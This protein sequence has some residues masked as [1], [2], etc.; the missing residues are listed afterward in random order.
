MTRTPL[1]ALSL[2]LGGI[3]AACASPES[4]PAMEP[5]VLSP[6]LAAEVNAEAPA[7]RGPH[8]R[9]VWTRDVGD[10]TDV[11]SFGNQLTLMGYDSDDGAGERVLLEQPAGYARPLVSASGEEIVFSVRE[12]AA[13]YAMEW[14]GTGRRRIADGFGLTVWPEPG[15]GVEWVYVGDDQA[16][17]DPPSYRSVYR[18]RLD[19]TGERELVWDAQPVSGDS[20]QL[21]A[22]GRYAGGLF[23]WPDAGVADLQTGTWTA[24]GDGCWTSFAGDGSDLFW[25]FDGSHRSLTMVDAKTDQRWQ[26]GINTAPG[27]DGFEVYH[28]RWTND[29]RFLVMTGPYTVGRRDNKIRGGGDQVEIWL[30]QFSADFSQVEEW[31]QVTHNDAPDFYPDAWIAPGDRTM[32]SAGGRPV[33]NADGTDDQGSQ[34]LV[35]EARVRSDVTVPTPESIA[36]YTNGLQALEYDVLEL[37]EGRYDEDIL[38]VAHWIIRDRE[39]LQDAERPRGSTHRLTV[40]LYESHPELEG[41]RLVMDSTAFTLP[42]YYELDSAP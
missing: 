9:V 38:V 6:A 3:A 32:A 11:I 5:T 7:P 37:V 40:E 21:S 28:P 4:S 13:V 27:I 26:V 24:I 25:Y 29:S 35:V 16:P 22:D 12:E 15:S 34:R 20:F 30:G 39:V 33:A 8:V 42:L 14:D 41:E 1:F 23:P 10:G 17:T 18:Y 31:T 2:L 36:P 19:A